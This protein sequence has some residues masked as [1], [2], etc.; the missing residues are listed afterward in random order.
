MQRTLPGKPLTLSAPPII[1]YIDRINDILDFVGSAFVKSHTSSRFVIF[2]HSPTSFAE[3]EQVV[4]HLGKT[5]KL[6]IPENVD[7]IYLRDTNSRYPKQ[8]TGEDGESTVNSFQY[9]QT[10]AI[11]KNLRFHTIEVDIGE[12]NFTIANIM[13]SLY[14]K[15]KTS[16]GYPN[17]VNIPLKDGYTIDRNHHDMLYS[18]GCTIKSIGQNNITIQLHDSST[19]IEITGIC[20]HNLSSS[21]DQIAS[22][23]VEDNATACELLDT[24]IE[25]HGVFETS[26][27]C[28]MAMMKPHET[29]TQFLNSSPALKHIYNSCIERYYRECTKRY[30]S[31]TRV[32]DYGQLALPPVI[33]TRQ[34]S[35]WH[36]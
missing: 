25:A 31:Y 8:I 10:P 9:S 29:M 24:V 33:P 3:F 6:V 16:A 7:I 17:I 4:E 14:G 30:S 15:M 11:P 35:E 21:S 32:P 34:H 23:L 28:C 36:N 27:N 19:P 1:P 13:D 26:S 5:D 22:C 2:I 12:S 20:R 18:T